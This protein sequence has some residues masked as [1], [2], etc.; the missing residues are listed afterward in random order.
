MPRSSPVIAVEDIAHVRYQAPDL[1]RMESFLL[2]FGLSRARRT[3]DTLHMRGQGEAPHAHITHLGATAATL[4]FGL[5][6]QSEADLHTLAR[7]LGLQV[8][9]N[10]EPGGG[11]V[12]RLQDPA[13][14]RV[15]VLHGQAP[16]AAA[17]A[18]RRPFVGNNIERRERVGKVL[19]QAPGP[20]NV[21]RLGHVVLLVPD[22]A[23]ALTFYTEVLGLRVSDTYHG[24][25]PSAPVFAFLHCG[26]GPRWTDHHTVALGTPPGGIERGR[27]DHIAFEV[28]DL[29]DLMAGHVHLR[30]RGWKHSWGVGRHVEGSQIFDY[31]RDP[32]GHKV[33]H[34]TDGD[35]VNH[36]HVPSHGPMRPEGLS[37]WAPPFN[38]EFFE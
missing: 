6:A 35:R 34:W 29:D 15:D 17:V 20:S 31:W 16:W 38:P 23:A 11:S 7:H 10:D 14:L 12:V 25:D 36:T 27:F 19:R 28:V 22:F 1:D 37:Q 32:F 18:V 9:A 26:L 3:P 2:D 4:G 24:P 5:R 8:Q 33:E 13:G 30:E 21:M